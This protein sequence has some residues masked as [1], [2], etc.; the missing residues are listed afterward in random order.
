M[1][2]GGK[3]DV[4]L[5]ACPSVCLHRCPQI[6]IKLKSVVGLIEFVCKV[7]HLLCPQPANLGPSR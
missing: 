5:S 6:N 3:G 4:C 7:P 2:G 1:A